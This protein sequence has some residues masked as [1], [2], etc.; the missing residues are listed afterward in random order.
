[1]LAGANGTA[2]PGENGSGGYVTT[3]VVS[4][5]TPEPSSVLLGMG[6]LGLLA[7]GTLKHRL[8]A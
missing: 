3:D 2:G 4:I 6:L 5:A 8:F 7:V 1:L